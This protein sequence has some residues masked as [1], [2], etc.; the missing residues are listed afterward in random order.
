ML[1]ATRAQIVLTVSSDDDESLGNMDYS[2]NTVVL[3]L[4]W[5]HIAIS[6]GTAPLA[7]DDW[8][9]FRVGSNQSLHRQSVVRFDYAPSD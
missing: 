3:A 4:E 1:P 2:E 8:G 7:S 9:G 5:V 6:R